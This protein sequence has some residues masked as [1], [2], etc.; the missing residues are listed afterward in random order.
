[1]TDIKNQINPDK[2][3]FLN[4]VTT[5]SNTSFQ[6]FLKDLSGRILTL[7]VSS[8]DS[9]EE[10]KN[11]VEDK[12]GVPPNQ[13]RLV[14]ATK[15]LEG[16]KTL[17]DF[18]I[19]K[20][21]T[22]QLLLKLNGGKGEH[23]TIKKFMQKQIVHGNVTG[24]RTKESVTALILKRNNEGWLHNGLKNRILFANGYG[25]PNMQKLCTMSLVVE[26]LG[27]GNC[28]EMADWAAVQLTE[29]TTKQWIY[30]CSFNGT[31][32]LKD[33]I[34][35]NDATH[36]LYYNGQVRNNLDHVMVI[37]YPLDKAI[38]Q[39][40]PDIATVVDTWYDNLVCSLGDYMAGKHPYYNYEYS[41]D[42][43]LVLNRG[44]FIIQKKISAIG[45][46][47][48]NDKSAAINQVAMLKAQ[49]VDTTNRPD[50]SGKTKYEFDIDENRVQDSRSTKNLENLLIQS[51]KTNTHI[52]EVSLFNEAALTEVLKSTNNDVLRILFDALDKAPK[53][54]FNLFAKV[55][56]S[57]TIHNFLF[58]QYPFD[59][60]LATFLDTVFAD[61][62]SYKAKI[63]KVLS[64]AQLSAYAFDKKATLESLLSINALQTNLKKALEKAD[65][66]QWKDFWKLC[67]K[68]ESYSIS[69]K[70]IKLD[71]AI[72]KI[73]ETLPKESLYRVLDASP[74][75]FNLFCSS[76]NSKAISD[77]FTDNFMLF[78]FTDDLAN[79]LND[80]FSDST[81]SQTKI[82]K[83]LSE[84]QLSYYAF[85]KKATFVSLLGLN[86]IETNLKKAL[87]SA[88]SSEWEN[89][90]ELCSESDINTILNTLI[91]FDTAIVAMGIKAL[92]KQSFEDYILK[93]TSI[94]TVTV[95]GAKGNIMQAIYAQLKAFGIRK[96]NQIYKAKLTPYHW[97]GYKG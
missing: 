3:S 23:G 56:D 52:E 94:Q 68:P 43:N 62:T 78:A 63:L 40:D 30:V 73:I 36:P 11:L 83:A 61:S 57:Y 8:T 87:K 14:F 31:F 38:T 20:E 42:A 28:N 60:N 49:Y 95:G 97:A 82:L 48:S 86:A 32:N 37:T 72:D 79:F 12:T 89:F 44:N 17:G 18:N 90:W 47:F 10:T 71:V 75:T 2:V 46:P 39:M 81:T 55:A 51:K 19:K 58:F 22:L 92:S 70:R 69:N 59:D 88:F 29:S 7:D 91:S 76:A 4:P 27:G 21:S 67:S 65:S 35:L 1:M 93:H 50:P 9:I 77:F 53:K 6:I 96:T 66:K 16:N 13:Q 34:N 33:S 5:S 80:V 45:K 25:N 24:L 74:K 26:G 64:D 15:Q 54:S 41:K 85:N 84:N